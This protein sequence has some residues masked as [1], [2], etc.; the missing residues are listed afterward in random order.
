M[1]NAEDLIKAGDLDGAMAAL[2]Q[3]VRT[4][5]QDARLRIFLFQL[6][7]LQGDWTR[8]IQ[9]L[10]TCAT[11]D[12]SAMHMAQTFRQA[13]ICEVFR[14]KV[15]AGE[16]APLIFGAPQ[17]WIAH[18]VEALAVQAA[19]N[20]AAAE[21]LRGRAFEAAMTSAGTLNE[22]GFSW[23]ADGDPRLGPVLEL[24][25]NGKYYWVPFSA[26]GALKISPPADLRDAVWMPVTIEWANGGDA[27]GLI[28]T[29]YA[30]PQTAAQKLA[31]ATEWQMQGDAVLAG[32]G[33]R[34]LVTD[35]TEIALMEV[36][37]ITISSGACGD[38]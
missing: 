28:P 20:I 37:S 23:I 38:G 26:L 18:L 5:P 19:G 29:R 7:C 33:Q 3:A 25:L 11:L 2:T 1:M 12:P 30:R 24:V 27:V 34:S 35:A 21:E 16:K 6:L 13:I 17:D 8:A 32:L 9:Q 14:E 10:K 31:R 15:F 4:A 36:R 22:T